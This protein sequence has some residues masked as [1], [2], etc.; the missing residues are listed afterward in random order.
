MARHHHSRV[1]TRPTDVLL[2]TNTFARSLDSVI[3]IL[4]GRLE[5][6]IK[7]GEA[8]GNIQIFT[9]RIINSIADISAALAMRARPA[10]RCAASECGRRSCEQVE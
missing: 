9:Q 6:I 7:M 1:G 4:K 10:S 2:Q 3:T 8:T 5:A